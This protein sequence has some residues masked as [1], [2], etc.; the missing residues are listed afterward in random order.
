MWNYTKDQLIS[1]IHVFETINKLKITNTKTFT[2]KE[3]IYKKK[4][5]NN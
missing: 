5:L 4:L 1:Q 3:L 2:K